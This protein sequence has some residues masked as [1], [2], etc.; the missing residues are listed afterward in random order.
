MTM[1]RRHFEVVRLEVGSCCVALVVNMVTDNGEADAAG[2]SLVGLESAND[3][4][5]GGMVTTGGG[6]VG[7]TDEKHGVGAG[8]YVGENTLLG[9]VTDFIGGVLDPEGTFRAK[10]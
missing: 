2:F 7:M 9:E 5:V 1:L 8:G 4:K 3:A 6:H 10:F